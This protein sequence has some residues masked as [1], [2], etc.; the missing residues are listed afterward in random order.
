MLTAAQ[1]EQF[2]RE[3]CLLGPKVL[4]DDQVEVLRE[5]V[6]RVIRD[7]Q[8]KNVAQPVRI[9][10]LGLPDSPVWQIVNIWEGSDPFREL[11]SNKEVVEAAMQLSQAKQ[12]RLWHDQIQY[13]PAGK[14]GINPWHQDWPYWANISPQTEQVTAWIALDE[15]DE[16]NGCMSMVPGSHKWGNAI[17][18]VH[19]IKDFRKMPKLYKEHKLE[20]RLAPVP[21]GAVHFHHGLTWHGSHEN[22]SGRPRRAIALHFMTE[23][24][25]Y[26]QPDRKGH[27]MLQ[28]FEVQPGEQL[29][30]AHFPLLWDG[31]KV[32]KAPAVP[33]EAVA[34]K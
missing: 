29:K 2:D 18:F 24:T 8:N 17:E 6:E 22:S 13:K 33:K 3:G 15:V 20:A 1:V 31:E 21:K 14:G 26:A 23:R 7:Q 30:G 27:P 9:A 19:T 10:N 11:L 25:V 16:D 32:C 34:A 5:E 4:T 12:V 28:F